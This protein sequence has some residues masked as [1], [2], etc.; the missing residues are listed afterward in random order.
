MGQVL[1]DER[2]EPLAAVSARY[3]AIGRALEGAL[4]EWLGPD[5]VGFE[6]VSE[7]RDV[8]VL[9][10]SPAKARLLRQILP[11][12]RA[13]MRGF[14]VRSVKIGGGGKGR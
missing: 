2:L 13:T 1:R 10:A 4:P 6:L 8:M 5:G 3:E 9:S 7:D 12:L 11:T 14:G